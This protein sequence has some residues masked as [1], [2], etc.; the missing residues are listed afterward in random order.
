MTHYFFL[1]PGKDVPVIYYVALNYMEMCEKK[2]SLT[3]TKRRKR[4]SNEKSAMSA[5]P[6]FRPILTFHCFLRMYARLRD[7]HTTIF[8]FYCYPSDWLKNGIKRNRFPF[9]V[10][11][12]LIR[13]KLQLTF[14][15]GKFFLLPCLSPDEAL[16]SHHV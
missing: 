16:R 10:I 4:L 2:N 7:I 13:L 9:Y 12:R 8:Q 11:D 15:F 5:I 14:G 6:S 3:D 1:I